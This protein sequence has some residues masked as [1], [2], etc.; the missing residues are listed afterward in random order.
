MSYFLTHWGFSDMPPAAPA[1]P[2][3]WVPTGPKRV[4]HNDAFRVSRDRIAPLPA[5]GDEGAV[6]TD[7]ISSRSNNL[8]PQIR[9]TPPSRDMPRIIFRRRLILNKSY[10]IGPLYDHYARGC[11]LGLSPP[12]PDPM[13]NTSRERRSTGGKH[14]LT[15]DVYGHLVPGANIAWVDRL[16]AKTRPQQSAT[17]A[18]PGE[19]KASEAG[20]SAAA[21]SH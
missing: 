9:G 10:R 11:R 13:P 4:Y 12:L 8:Y 15:V 1:E 7:A 21:G 20:R 18:Q 6:S 3:E 5:N 19:K 2:V 17:P 14:R 16:D